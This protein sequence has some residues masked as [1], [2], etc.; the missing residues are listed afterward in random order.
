MVSVQYTRVRPGASGVFHRVNAKRT[1]RAT[2]K[3]KRETTASEAVA[4][5]ASKSVSGLRGSGSFVRNVCE[6]LPV[7]SRMRNVMK[8]MCTGNWRAVGTKEKVIGELA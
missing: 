7:S 8:G 1:M 3:M 5:V 2:T 6:A 4:P